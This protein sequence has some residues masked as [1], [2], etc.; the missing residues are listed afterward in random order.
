MK[1]ERRPLVGTRQRR[2]ALGSIER[3]GVARLSAVQ[4]LIQVLQLR[5][6]EAPVVQHL[7]QAVCNAGRIMSRPKIA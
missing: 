7:L 1:A 5:R 2:H 4:G 3:K 6:Q